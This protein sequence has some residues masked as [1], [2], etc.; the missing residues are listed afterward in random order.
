MNNTGFISVLKYVIKFLVYVLTDFGWTV[1]ALFNVDT[2][3]CGTSVRQVGRFSSWGTVEPQ[4]ES[5][6]R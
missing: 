6:P 1:G 5:I 4:D 2:P 3:G